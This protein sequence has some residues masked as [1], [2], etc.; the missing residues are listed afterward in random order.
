ML[1]FFA[2]WFMDGLKKTLPSRINVVD[3]Q[4]VVKMRIVVHLEIE[5]NMYTPQ[6]ITN[7]GASI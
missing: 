2:L 6:K 1:M 7:Q 4:V 3:Q 5:V